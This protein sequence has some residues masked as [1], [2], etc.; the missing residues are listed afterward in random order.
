LRE[1]ENSLRRKKRKKRGEERKK[2]GE[3]QRSGNERK[4]KTLRESVSGRPMKMP[5]DK[6]KL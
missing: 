1:P 3:E 5:R 2:R 6:G 4:M